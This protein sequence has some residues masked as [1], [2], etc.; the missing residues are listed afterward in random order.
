MNYTIVKREEIDNFSFRDE[1][2]VILEDSESFGDDATVQSMA[3][4]ALVDLKSLPSPVQLLFSDNS[5]S[6][7]PPLGTCSVSEI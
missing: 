5:V 2:L 1:T 4:G 7:V 3:D 6:I